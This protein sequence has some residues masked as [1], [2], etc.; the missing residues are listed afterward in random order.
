MQHRLRICWVAALQAARL[1]A[2]VRLEQGGHVGPAGA[3]LDRGLLLAQHLHEARAHRAADALRPTARHLVTLLAGAATCAAPLLMRPYSVRRMLTHERR[4]VWFCRH[5]GLTSR[6]LFA[7]DPYCARAH[8][9][10]GCEPIS[11]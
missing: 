10:S 11:Q 3:A 8:P 9:S 5:A 4:P 7:Q 2:R 6:P 1:E